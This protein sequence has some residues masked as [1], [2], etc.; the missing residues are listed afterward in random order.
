MESFSQGIPRVVYRK[1]IHAKEDGFALDRETLRLLDAIDGEKDTVRI[2]GELGIRP[3]DL[4][5]RVAWLLDQGI[6]EPVKKRPLYLDRSFL[7]TLKAHL[8]R[9]IGPLGEFIIEEVISDMNLSEDRIPVDRASEFV[10]YIAHQIPRE[11]RRIRFQKSMKRIM[12]Y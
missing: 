5:N 7:G 6:I 8:A 11:D 1:V 2:A 9:A 4:V 3:P 10:S 12:P